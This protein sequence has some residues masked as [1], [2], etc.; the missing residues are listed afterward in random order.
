MQEAPE[1]NLCLV[2]RVSANVQQESVLG[3]H[4]RMS[5]LSPCKLS[6][7]AIYRGHTL[8]LGVRIGFEFQ[9]H[10]YWQPCL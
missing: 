3:P 5:L 1:N 10:L 9:L 2:E 8:G 4:F 6:S 7:W